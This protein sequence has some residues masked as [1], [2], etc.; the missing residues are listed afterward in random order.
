M[1]ISSV[2]S[3][4]LNQAIFSMNS[5]RIPQGIDITQL[6]KDDAALLEAAQEFEAY[7]L[8]MMMRAMRDT[9]NSENG[10]LPQSNSEQI[11]QEMMDEETT[12]I[13]AQGGGVGFAQQIFK[14]LTA[15]RNPIQ[16]ALVYDG[17]Y[18]GAINEPKEI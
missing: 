1:E 3:N 16:Q 10:I 6:S 9:V 15:H 5:Q 14:Q 2:N 18:G 13:A 8:F 17:S 7:F 12:R 4:L 11:F